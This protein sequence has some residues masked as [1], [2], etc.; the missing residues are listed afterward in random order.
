MIKHESFPMIVLG[1]V[2]SVLFFGMAYSAVTDTALTETRCCNLPA[3]DAVSNLSWLPTVLKAGPGA[4]PVDRWER[5][6]NKCPGIDI[7]IT[8]MP[9]PAL[10][11]L[12]I[13]PR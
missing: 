5:R 2:L 10:F 8:P 12:E 4:L 9:D 13:V 1:I 7:E 6:I 3:R 11:L